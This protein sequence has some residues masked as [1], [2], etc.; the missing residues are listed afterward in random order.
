M[1]IE[2]IQSLLVDLVK[3]I[4]CRLPGNHTSQT[5]ARSAVE[6]GDTEDIQ[7]LINQ[8]CPINWDE[9][10]ESEDPAVFWALQNE[11]L[12]IVRLLIPLINM[13]VRNRNNLTVEKFVRLDIQE[14]STRE[15]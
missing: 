3:T 2:I 7:R 13:E 14:N 11:K 6:V 10:T 12:D 15:S 4:L 8:S 1:N 5:L 9:K